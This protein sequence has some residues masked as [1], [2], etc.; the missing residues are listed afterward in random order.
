MN[1][2]INVDIINKKIQN[3][4]LFKRGDSQRIKMGSKGYRLLNSFWHFKFTHRLVNFVLLTCCTGCFVNMKVTVISIKTD[5]MMRKLRCHE[6]ILKT[7][8]IVVI[9]NVVFRDSLRVHGIRQDRMRRELV[10]RGRI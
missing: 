4:F 6:P 9:L 10:G 7:I 2:V 3:K 8:G 1:I 5:S